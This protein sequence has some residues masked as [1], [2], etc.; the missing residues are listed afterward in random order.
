[1]GDVCLSLEL[2]LDLAEA[3]EPQLKLCIEIE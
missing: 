2:E 1:L 3:G